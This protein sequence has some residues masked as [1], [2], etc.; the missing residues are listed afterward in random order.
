MKI[1]KKEMRRVRK[2]AEERFKE[3]TKADEAQ[4]KKAAK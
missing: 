1:R 2:R 3:R 4:K